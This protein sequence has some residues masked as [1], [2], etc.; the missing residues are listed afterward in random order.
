MKI[1]DLF[2]GCKH[3]ATIQIMCA[4]HGQTMPE[5]EAQRIANFVRTGDS[6]FVFVDKT[7]IEILEMRERSERLAK[8]IARRVFRSVVLFL[9]DGAIREVS[10]D[11]MTETW[12]LI[13]PKRVIERDDREEI[14]PRKKTAFDHA[15]PARPH[16]KMSK[17]GF[18]RTQMANDS[19]ERISRL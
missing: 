9:H 2:G 14:V 1:S 12:R 13:A 15:M 3:T 19:Q 6:C 5:H 7:G 18:S 4:T 10:R 8:L 11:N 17:R 16:K